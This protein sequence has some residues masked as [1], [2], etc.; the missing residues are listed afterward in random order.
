MILLPGSIALADAPASLDD[1][2]RTWAKKSDSPPSY[3]Y[4]LVDLN[5]DGI[6]DAIVLIT[7]RDFCGSGGC[8]MLIARGTNTGFRLVS[9]STIT[10]TPI[11]V[12]SERRYGWHTLLVTVGGGGANYGQVLMRFNGSRYPLNPSLQPYARR[13][14]RSAATDVRLHE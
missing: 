4:A 3:Q 10:R 12:A 7:N 8:A 5:D 1:V 6:S 9:S 14:D 11:L 2:V 13:R